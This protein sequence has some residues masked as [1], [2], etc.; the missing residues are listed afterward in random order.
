MDLISIVWTEI[1]VGIAFA[2]FAVFLGSWKFYC[3]LKG[4]K[5]FFDEL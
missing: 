4:Q 2:G 5:W 1:Y 3:K